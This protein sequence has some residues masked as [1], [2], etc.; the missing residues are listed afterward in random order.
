MCV[1]LYLRVRPFLGSL[2]RFAFDP[3]FTLPAYP[4]LSVSIAESA[5][6]CTVC[7][8]VACNMLYDVCYT[9]LLDKICL[10]DNA[11]CHLTGISNVRVNRAK[12]PHLEH[13]FYTIDNANYGEYSALSVRTMRTTFRLPNRPY[14]QSFVSQ[15]ANHLIPKLRCITSLLMFVCVTTT[16][17]CSYSR[18]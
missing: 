14:R 13:N 3:F 10:S 11:V 12:T 1:C 16:I 2:N 9:G 18:L 17:S 6:K 15:I 7:T 4:P 5:A 8:T